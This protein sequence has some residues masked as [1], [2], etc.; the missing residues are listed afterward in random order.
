[1]RN[2]EKNSEQIIELLS[3]NKLSTVNGEVQVS[4]Y[5]LKQV[6]KASSTVKVINSR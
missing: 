6:Y 3:S 2:S 4:Q 5:W 1:M